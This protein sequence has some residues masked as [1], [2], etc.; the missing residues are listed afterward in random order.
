MK[1]VQAT[2]L[3]HRAFSVFCGLFIQ[4]AHFILSGQFAIVLGIVAD[5]RSFFNEKILGLLTMR[6]N[7]R[8]CL[9]LLLWFWFLAY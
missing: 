1:R 5:K 7:L 6:F 4:L 3:Q 2:V 8:L 9:S